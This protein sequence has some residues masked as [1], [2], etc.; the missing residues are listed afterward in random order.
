MRYNECSFRTDGP[1][2][3]TDVVF[4]SSYFFPCA[5]PYVTPRARS[6]SVSLSPQKAT[7]KAIQIRQ[8]VLL[9]AVTVVAA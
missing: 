8:Q 3:A 4:I 2:S 1:I 6:L 9:S 7:K 5:V